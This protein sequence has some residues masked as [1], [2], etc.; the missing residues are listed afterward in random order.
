MAELL[1]LSP[2][3]TPNAG[4]VEIPDGWRLAIPAGI[5][6]IYRLAQ[7][8]D[9]ARVSRWRLPWRAP[10]TL[11]LRARLSAPG[12]PG[13]WGFGMWNDPFGLSL[14]FGGTPGRLPALPETAWFFHA[15]PENHLALRDDLPGH[16]FFA[17]S[18][19]S[20]RLP[21]FLCAPALLAAPFL[22]LRPVARLLRKL[23]ARVVRQEAVALSTDVTQWHA[24]SI[25]WLR[26]VLRF[27][28]DG[29]TVLETSLTPRPPLGLVLWIDNQYAAWTPE[30]RLGYGTLGNPPAW[31][32][33]S[34]VKMEQSA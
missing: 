8:D 11:S 19:R 23:A 12:L 14:G 15:S 34:G 9:Y 24:Y 28:M 27:E 2:R 7:L 3:H 5:K 25:H 1:S 32:E 22:L 21:A 6:G 30:G 16:G 18:M 29:Q 33:L 31:L 26:Q 17:G 20:P 13:T 10:V 4:V